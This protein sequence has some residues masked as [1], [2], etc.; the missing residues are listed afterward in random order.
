MGARVGDLITLQVNREGGAIN[1]LPLLVKAIF[2]EVSI[3]GYYTVYMDRAVL[4]QALGFDARYSA[5]VGLYLK[6]Y[7][8]AG[9]VAARLSKALAGRFTAQPVVSFMP[10]IRTMLSALTLVSYGI[11]ALLSIVIAVGILNLYRV[12][13]YE[14][15]G[16]S[17]PCVPSASRGP[18]S[19]TSSSARPFF[20]AVCSI[21]AGLVLSV[22]RSFCGLPRSIRAVPPDLTY[23][24][25]A[26]I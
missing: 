12:I 4:D 6:D 16:K 18:R 2:R 26:G 1:T 7:R 21:V 10:E 8:S 14:R 25:T 24:S 15:T 5:T 11:L 20:S 9:S 3:F 13:I 17:A 22:L 23:F 19:A